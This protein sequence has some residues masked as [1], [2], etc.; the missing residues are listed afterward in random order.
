MNRFQFIFA[1]VISLIAI[2]VYADY[3]IIIDAGSSGSRLHLFQHDKNTPL[4]NIKDIFS[5]STKP[6][7]S[8]YAN[9]PQDAGPALKKLLDDAVQQLQQAKVDMHAV[10]INVLGTAGM[11]LLPSATQEIIY[12]QVKH[13]LKNNYA[14]NVTKVETISGSLEGLYGWLDINYLKQTFQQHSPTVGSID[15]G[16]A[17]TEITF[18]TQDT[19][20]SADEMAVKINGQLYTV[21]SK[22]FLGMG[23]D[24][25]RKTINTN[26]SAYTC[27][28][29][30]FPL[31][32]TVFGNFN[33]IN[34]RSLYL[35]FLEQHHLT[36]AL[37]SLPTNQAFIAYSGVFYAYDFLAAAQQPDYTHVE[38]RIQAVC[39]HPWNQLQQDYP[40]I[41]PTYL[42]VFCA[43]GIYINNLLHAY[44]LEGP[45]LTVT[46]TINQQQIDWT[47]GALLHTLL[48]ENKT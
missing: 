47:L 30:N 1:I 21:F 20:K 33:F 12:D 7:L 27:Y 42:S 34:C 4:P 5:V 38:E 35:D 23:Q 31:T 44:G 9:H 41:A 26:Q 45:Q 39:T 8:A 2:P 28:P 11:R 24:E 25:A 40:K 3:T 22:S 32:E 13:Y 17:S 36:Q 16:G 14:F 46:N 10:A 29:K 18:A 15:M 19:S 48:A 43:N 37:I 6:G